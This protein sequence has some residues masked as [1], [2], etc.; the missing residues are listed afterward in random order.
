VQ[1]GPL[2]PNQRRFLDAARRAVLAT[3]A[4]DGHVRLV[5]VCFALE[6]TDPSHDGA[7]AIWTPLDEKPKATTDPLALARVRDILARPAVTLLVDQWS[8]DW[9]DLAWLRLRGTASLAGPQDP[10]HAA[11]VVRLRDRYPQY[12]GHDLEHRPMIRILIQAATAWGNVAPP[13]R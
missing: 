13:T 2:S 1:S 7:V 4:P 6:P 5:P 9:S 12:A 8:E 3:I 11:M 10:G